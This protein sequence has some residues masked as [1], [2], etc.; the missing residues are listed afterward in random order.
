MDGMMLLPKRNSFA[1]TGSGILD[2]LDEAPGGSGLEMFLSPEEIAG[3]DDLVYRPGKRAPED[4][5]PRLLEARDNS[6]SGG[7]GDKSSG[8]HSNGIVEGEYS[9]LR[10]PFDKTGADRGSVAGKIWNLPNSAIGAAY[11]GLGYLAGWPSKWLGL[12]ENAPGV[13]IG[14]NSVQFTDNPF[15]GVGAITLGNVEVFNGKP[16]DPADRRVPPTPIGQ[17][18]E[19]HTYQ[20]EQL[21][22]LYLPSN[23]LGGLAGVL[24]DGEL[25]GPHNWNESGPGQRP[26]VP[27]RK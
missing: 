14:N 25:H 22:P 2:G 10:Y 11:G 13:T 15:G 12:Q 6:L 23:I 18:E 8:P 16:S 7:A 9:G 20:G 5:E 24:I 19:Q 26:P 3:I 27:W 21:G 1:P 17:H 4:S